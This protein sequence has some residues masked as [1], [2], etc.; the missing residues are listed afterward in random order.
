[1]SR[2]GHNLRRDGE[3]SG[4]LLTDNESESGRAVLELETDWTTIRI[5][6]DFLSL[7]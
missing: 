4:T 3:Q 1:M 2:N 7:I 6:E 5:F